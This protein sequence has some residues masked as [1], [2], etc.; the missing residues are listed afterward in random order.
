MSTFSVG[1][2][3]LLFAGVAV[4]CAAMM[5]SHFFSGRSRQRRAYWLG[6]LLGGS[7]VVISVAHRG[8]DWALMLAGTITFYAVFWAFMKTPY[9]KLGDRILA[10]TLDNRRPDPSSRANDHD[11]SPDLPADRY[12][13]L[14]AGAFWWLATLMIS[15]GGAAVTI[16]GW[17]NIRLSLWAGFLTLAAGLVGYRDATGG[18]ARA[19]GQRLPALLATAASVLLFGV[20]PVLYL[21]AYQI[22]YRTQAEH[23]GDPNGNEGAAPYMRP[24]GRLRP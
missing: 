24:T 6:W 17:H 23:G 18:F 7:L 22:G 19:R 20:P 10:L 15:A 16:G 11:P 1:S 21:L 5:G 14:S 9:L 8:L 2:R 3:L 12:G 4:L 13:N